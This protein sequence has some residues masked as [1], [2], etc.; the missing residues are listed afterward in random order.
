MSHPG[1]MAQGGVWRGG[2][3]V[4]AHGD[5]MRRAIGAARVEANPW[6]EMW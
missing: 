6:R 2:E 3:F 1:T 5:V 4:C